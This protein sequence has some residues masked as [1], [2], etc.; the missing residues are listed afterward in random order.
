MAD[1][2]NRVYVTTV[3]LLLA[4][5]PVAS[6]AVE[7]GVAAVPPDWWA[8]GGKWFTFWAAGVRLLLAGIRQ[9]TKPAF[10]AR[11]IFKF[12]GTESFPVIRELGMANI[13]M[14]LL[15]VASLILPDWRVA[16]AAVG[17]LYY[18]LAAAGHIVRK[19]EGA[20]ERVALYSDCWI[21][22]ILAADVAHALA[23]AV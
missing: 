21:F 9:T 23:A 11:T 15:G 5:L 22:V 16:A 6:M 14:G 18:G 12:E 3:V 7:R 19:P 2:A 13:S 8:L 17:G 1:S 4:I 10:T 20:N